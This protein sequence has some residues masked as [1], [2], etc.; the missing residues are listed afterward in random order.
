MGTPSDEA[1]DTAEDGRVVRR[2]DDS[3]GAA[4]K[5]DCVVTI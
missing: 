1:A 5:G 2:A 3:F 4:G